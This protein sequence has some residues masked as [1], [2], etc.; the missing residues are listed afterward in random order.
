M[1]INQLVPKVYDSVVVPIFWVLFSV[2]FIVFFWGVVEFI[3]DAGSEDGRKKGRQHMLW[4]IVGIL[5]MSSVFGITKVLIDTIGLGGKAGEIEGP[6]VLQ[7]ER[8]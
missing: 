2:A 3:R 7:G 6:P 5:I 8:G 4:G 1:D